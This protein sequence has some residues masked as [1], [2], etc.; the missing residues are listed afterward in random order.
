M[1][2]EL[3]YERQKNKKLSGLRNTFAWER[4]KL[5]I[6]EVTTTQFTGLGRKF[7]IN[8]GHADGVAAGQFVLGN[9][10]IIGVVSDVSSS[11]ATV[12]LITDCIHQLINGFEIEMSQVLP[13]RGLIIYPV[14][15]CP[16]FKCN[17]SNINQRYTDPVEIILICLPT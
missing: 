13:V 14:L 5:L 10:S 3:R 11:K 4:A 12:K 1:Q 16:V 8:R 2:A 15:L 6:A 17:A 7:I 9:Y